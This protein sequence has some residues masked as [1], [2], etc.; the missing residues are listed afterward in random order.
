MLPIDFFPVFWLKAV[1]GIY[2]A[3]RVDEEIGRTGLAGEHTAST[4]DIIDE[5]HVEPC[6]KPRF[7]VLL[8]KLPFNQLL[9]IAAY[10]LLVG[11]YIVILMEII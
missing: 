8:L 5:A 3:P 10:L 9:E 1:A 6:A 2:L 7:R 11:N 4:F